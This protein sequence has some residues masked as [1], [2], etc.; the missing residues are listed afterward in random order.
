MLLGSCS[1]NLNSSLQQVEAGEEETT[2]P[3]EEKPATPAF[4]EVQPMGTGSIAKTDTGGGAL[5]S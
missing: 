5:S 4:V 1:T 3:N 2:A